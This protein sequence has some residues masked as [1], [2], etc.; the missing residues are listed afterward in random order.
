MDVY[1]CDQI[2]MTAVGSLLPAPISR[3]T[4]HLHES[5]DEVRPPMCWPLQSTPIAGGFI[6][7]RV[8]INNLIHGTLFQG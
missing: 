1:L 7:M 2:C 4:P 5:R 8:D 6:A 3:G